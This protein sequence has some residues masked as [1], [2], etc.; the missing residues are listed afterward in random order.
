MKQ[1]LGELGQEPT[2][3]AK[4]EREGTTIFEICMRY[5]HY[6]DTAGMPVGRA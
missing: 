6:L 4:Q 5:Q 1:A 2:N 3:L